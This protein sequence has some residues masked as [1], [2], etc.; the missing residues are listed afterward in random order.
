[1]RSAINAVRK[2][3]NGGVEDH[4]D[5]GVSGTE[6]LEQWTLKV[7][8]ELA[9]RYINDGSRAAGRSASRSCRWRC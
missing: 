5:P 9:S 8:R 2:A 7:S 1:M 4:A 3:R 6:L